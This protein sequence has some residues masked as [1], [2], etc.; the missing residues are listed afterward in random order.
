M[1]HVNISIVVLIVLAAVNTLI[2]L[3]AIWLVC[4]LKCNYHNNT[5]DELTHILT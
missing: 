3:F 1:K 2:I 4:V 5:L